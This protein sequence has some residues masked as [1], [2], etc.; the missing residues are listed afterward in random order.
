MTCLAGDAVPWIEPSE[1]RWSTKMLGMEDCL[2]LQRN[3]PRTELQHRVEYGKR[4]RTQCVPSM[5]LPVLPSE[6]RVEAEDW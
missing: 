4:C 6:S 2:S 5:S 3:M 1:R